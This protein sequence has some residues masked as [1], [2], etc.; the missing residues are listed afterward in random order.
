MRAAAP[1]ACP[2]CPNGVLEPFYEVRGVPAH[3]VLL[4]KTREEARGYPT[5]D[6]VLGWCPAC[7]FVSNLAFDVA[8][9]EYSTSYEEVQTFSPTFNAFASKLVDHLVEERGIQGRDV[10]EIAAARESSCWSS[11]SAVATAAWESIR[12]TWRSAPTA[13]E[14]PR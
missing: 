11:V 9:N 7:A 13:R 8:L 3:S 5:G 1:R 2:N 4:M 6:V 12:A 10:V 14:P